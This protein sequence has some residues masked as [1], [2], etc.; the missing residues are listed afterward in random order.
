M[1]RGMSSPVRGPVNAFNIY[2]VYGLPMS[3]VNKRLTKNPTIRDYSSIPDKAPTPPTPQTRCFPHPL[4][5]LEYWKTFATTKRETCIYLMSLKSG[6]S[7]VDD[8]RSSIKDT[9]YWRC[10]AMFWLSK[11]RYKEGRRRKIS[12]PNYWRCEADFWRDNCTCTLEEDQAN[13][14]NIQ[15]PEYWKCESGFWKSTCRKIHEDAR[16]DGIDDPK[17]WECENMFYEELLRPL[18]DPDF[19][20]P[21]YHE[22]LLRANGFIYDSDGADDSSKTPPRRSARLVKL[23]QKVA[24]KDAAPQYVTTVPTDEGRTKKRK[25]DQQTATT[26]KKRKS[27]S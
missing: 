26:N 10:E 11:S 20:K 18:I 6:T 3:L 19:Q 15:D 27:S 13:R 4:Y 9:Y 8:R 25:K 7:D 23:H 24:A 22:T 5:P 16:Y 12:D 17:Y 1:F 21:S 14:M 2:G